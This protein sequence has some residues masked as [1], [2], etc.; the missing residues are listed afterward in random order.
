MLGQTAD[1]FSWTHRDGLKKGDFACK[2]VV[3]PP[4][5]LQRPSTSVYDVLIIGGGYSGLSA[6]RDLTNAGI[7]APTAL[8]FLPSLLYPS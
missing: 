7:F 8:P 1:G 5:N 2:G 3:F 6:A 4:S